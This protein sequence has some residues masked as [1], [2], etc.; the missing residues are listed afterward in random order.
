[1]EFKIINAYYGSSSFNTKQMSRLINN[2][3][4]DCQA[5]GIETKT[6]AEIESLLRSWEDEQKK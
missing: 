1:M 5:C 3:V 4:Q 2:L 6:S